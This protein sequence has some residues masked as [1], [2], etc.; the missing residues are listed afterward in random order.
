MNIRTLLIPLTLAA[1]AACA[2][3]ADG[4]M[5][6]TVSVVGTGTVEAAPDRV[7][8][9][10]QA[11]ALE[12]APA[13]ARAAVD[14]Q[15]ANARQALR[16]VG[17]DEDA[18]RAQSIR[19]QPEYQYIDQRRSLSGYRAIRDFS[20]MVEDI[21]GAGEVLDALLSAGLPQVSG[22]NYEVAEPEVQREAAR[23]LAIADARRKAEQLAAGLDAEVGAVRRIQLGGSPAP[24]GPGPVMMMAR[25]ADT[26]YAP[27]DLR[28]T[29]QV[30]V[31]FDLEVD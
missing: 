23:D 22:L 1:S 16:R 30:S 29:E 26:G 17:L 8:I 3:P 9:T 10:A 6:R 11:S 4:T 14:R 24:P 28:F 25:E 2:H 21:D 12:R 31:V 15:V 7:R 20:V 5:A 13:A 27:D 19:I 18:L